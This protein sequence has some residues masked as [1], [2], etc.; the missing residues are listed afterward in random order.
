M[1]EDAPNAT[2]H[3]EDGKRKASSHSYDL[4]NQED[5]DNGVVI[6]GLTGSIEEW[7]AELFKKKENEIENESDDDDDPF[8]ELFKEKEDEIE[9]ESDDDDDPFAE[10]FKEKEDEIKDESDDDDDPF[11]ELFKETED[12]REAKEAK[13]EA[14]EAKARKWRE[15]V[16]EHRKSSEERN[17]RIE[18]R[19]MIRKAESQ[20]TI[21]ISTPPDK[22]AT[23]IN[24]T[25][26]VLLT[27]AIKSNVGIST[28][29]NNIPSVS[30]NKLLDRTAS[31]IKSP[32]SKQLYR[33]I[34]AEANFDRDNPLLPNVFPPSSELK[35]LPIK[36]LLVSEQVLVL[37]RTANN[38]KLPPS[39]NV[40][41]D[42]TPNNLKQP[43]TPLKQKPEAAVQVSS[44]KDV[45]TLSS[46]SEQSLPSDSSN[47][48]LSPFSEQS[49]SSLPSNISSPS[50]ELKAVSLSSSNDIKLQQQLSL[51]S[52]ND[53]L[54]T[55]ISSSS[56]NNTKLQQQ[57]SNDT[58]LHQQAS[59]DT[60]LIKPPPPSGL[61]LLSSKIL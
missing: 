33:A 29:S 45:T 35:S 8:A 25:E 43:S 10:L 2:D 11:A 41:S 17:M 16:R 21:M 7:I 18:E 19:K 1:T 58:K 6:D 34:N 55:S 27:I 52:S 47:T 61:L 60:K 42:R 28:Q 32:P 36:L 50:L 39:Y 51:S 49:L 38:I 56:S 15:R 13:R 30:Y 12:E 54:V 14:D 20:R 3:D 4:P 53:T 24:K 48:L 46:S 40:L 57:S 5:D 9:D 37:E 44:N 31:N 22:D 26:T 59:D 23:S